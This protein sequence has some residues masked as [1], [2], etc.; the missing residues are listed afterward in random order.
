[1]EK[2]DLRFAMWIS[3]LVCFARYFLRVRYYYPKP[4][5]SRGFR[6]I[7]LTLAIVLYKWGGCFIV[8]QLVIHLGGLVIFDWFYEISRTFKVRRFIGIIIT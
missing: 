4:K 2:C 7:T 6:F 1:M 5:N 3:S 8:Q